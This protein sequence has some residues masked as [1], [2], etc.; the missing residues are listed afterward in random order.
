M[1]FLTGPVFNR[2][3]IYYRRYRETARGTISS[4]FVNFF[5]H[6]IFFGQASTDDK[7]YYLLMIKIN[8]VVIFFDT[9]ILLGS[10]HGIGRKKS[11]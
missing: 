11:G 7:K 9:L 6:S 4:S 8:N 2:E 10:F 5:S 3:T 1:F